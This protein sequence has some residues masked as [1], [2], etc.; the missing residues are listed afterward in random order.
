[1]RH[2][3]DDEEIEDEGT[4]STQMNEDIEDTMQ[5]RFWIEEDT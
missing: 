5:R 1:L 3:D 2:D 4:V